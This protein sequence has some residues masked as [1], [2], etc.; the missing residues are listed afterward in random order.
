[1]K[2]R[3]PTYIFNLYRERGTTVVSALRERTLWVS[4]RRLWWLGKYAVGRQDDVGG[5]KRKATHIHIL[6]TQIIYWHCAGVCTVRMCLYWGGNAMLVRSR[7]FRPNT[8]WLFPSNTP[9]K[10]PSQHHSCG[11]RAR[12]FRMDNCE[13]LPCAR[14]G[15]NHTAT[16]VPTNS[17]IFGIGSAL[18][19]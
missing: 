16:T 17:F 15:R 2:I 7:R 3:R 12:F 14:A 10:T 5:L 13:A 4:I 1:M 8:K 19:A 9:R 18:V 11:R 6:H